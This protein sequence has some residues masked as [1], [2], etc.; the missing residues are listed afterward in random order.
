MLRLYFPRCPVLSRCAIPTHS[1]RLFTLCNDQ[2]NHYKLITPGVVLLGEN[3]PGKRNRKDFAP[4][5]GPRPPLL[6][7][8]LFAPCYTRFELVLPLHL[9]C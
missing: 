7:S 4:N 5:S 6:R 1:F 8:S 2:A 3:L 9:A